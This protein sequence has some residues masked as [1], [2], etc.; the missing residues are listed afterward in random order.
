MNAKDVILPQDS[1]DLIRLYLFINE[2]I[3][4]IWKEYVIHTDLKYI[5]ATSKI[6]AIIFS[7]MDFYESLLARIR[8]HLSEEDILELRKHDAFW[9]W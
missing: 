8:V 3:N 6:F 5:P 2:K 7:E 1:T 9:D 4:E